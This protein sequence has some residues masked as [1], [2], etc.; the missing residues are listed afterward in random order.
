M[1]NDDFKL[2]RTCWYAGE[3]DEHSMVKCGRTGRYVYGNSVACP[4]W[5]DTQVF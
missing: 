5:D 3:P 4:D 2:C 1:T